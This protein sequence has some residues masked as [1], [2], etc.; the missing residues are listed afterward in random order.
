MWTSVDPL[1]KKSP[2]T[3]VE[4]VS[5]TYRSSDIRKHDI[6]LSLLRLFLLLL[7]AFV[8]VVNMEEISDQ[9]KFLI[10]QVT[11]LYLIFRSV[12]S[13]GMI[14]M[15]YLFCIKSHFDMNSSINFSVKKLP[16]SKKKK[17]N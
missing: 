6:R 17:I 16:Y 13:I 3:Q 9:F 12:L 8:M 11:L 14:Q 1:S 4:E 15:G 10:I 7:L 5:W 2:P